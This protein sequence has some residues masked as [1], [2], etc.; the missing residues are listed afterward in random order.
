V[1]DVTQPRCATSQPRPTRGRD[2]VLFKCYGIHSNKMLDQYFYHN[3]IDFTWMCCQT[4]TP[5]CEIAV[6]EI[7][8]QLEFEGDLDFRGLVSDKVAY[9]R[10]HWVPLVHANGVNE[11]EQALV[12]LARETM[13]LH[14]MLEHKWLLSTTTIDKGTKWCRNRPVVEDSPLILRP[15]ILCPPCLVEN[16]GERIFVPPISG[17]PV[18]R[19]Q[20]VECNEV[21]AD[22]EALAH[23]N[24]QDNE[25]HCVTLEPEDTDADTFTN[26]TCRD[27]QSDCS[28]EEFGNKTDAAT[29]AVSTCRD[30]ESH[31][32]VRNNE[33][34]K[35]TF[36]SSESGEGELE[37]PTDEQDVDEADS[38]EG[39]TDDEENETDADA[40]VTTENENTD[41]RGRTY[42]FVDSSKNTSERS[43]QRDDEKHRQE[44]QRAIRLV[45][46][47]RTQTF[48]DEIP[49]N[50]EAR[51]STDYNET[52]GGR[53]T[54]RVRF[55]SPTEQGRANT[56]VDDTQGSPR[57]V[58]EIKK[59][60]EK[61]TR[62]NG[63][64]R[65]PRAE[66]TSRF[67]DTEE[68]EPCLVKPMHGGSNKKRDVQ[69][70][71][72]RRPQLENDGKHRL[73]QKRDATRIKEQRSVW[74]ADLACEDRT[75][76]PV[77]RGRGGECRQEAEER[78]EEFVVGPGRLE[79]G[80]RTDASVRSC[81][82][83]KQT[84]LF[85]KET[86]RAE[87]PNGRGDGLGLAL[88]GRRAKGLIG[89]TTEQP[90]SGIPIHGVSEEKDDVQTSNRTHTQRINRPELRH[91]DAASEGRS[92][93]TVQ[94][95]NGTAVASGAQDVVWT[96]SM[97]PSVNS[98]RSQRVD[99][100][101][102][103]YS[104]AVVE[105][106]SKPNVKS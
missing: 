95:E 6:A 22:A 66:Q 89:E 86:E 34:N 77:G 71:N 39:V 25:Q 49:G 82:E 99:E 67:I 78:T 80:G 106:R 51:H 55:S 26:S 24:E 83:R 64:V 87:C 13:Q 7:E 53:D 40:S 76:L 61:V 98:T 33:A 9:I 1:H 45:D 62:E 57:F 38:D 68:E 19:E 69:T 31:C 63:E 79:N 14:S 12:G 32:S 85:V 50:D 96:S 36:A 75:A 42:I 104:N 4:D 97:D 15:P 23:L 84:N 91:C 2:N 72:T 17:Q 48:V 11:E 10:G 73:H 41:I 92:K 101:K 21:E 74:L 88:E 100:P 43:Q 16:H 103:R 46:K 37:A 54:R 52:T 47:A 29:P 8:Q 102:L 105:G 90:R 44:G 94:D 3:P 60:P 56:F 18:T 93:P 70:A 65:R 30:E 20:A 35:D 27:K 58:E 81:Q 28:I 5:A 59:D